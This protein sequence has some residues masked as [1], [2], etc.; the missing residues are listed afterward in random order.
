MIQT[1]R[2]SF[3]KGLISFAA[4]P[5]IVR[6]ES[7]MPVKVMR[8]IPCN[9]LDMGG[10]GAPQSTWLVQW[11]ETSIYRWFD[12]ATGWHTEYLSPEEVFL[13]A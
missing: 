9:V 13:P 5:A 7:L 10:L 4:A 1:S 2:R 8:P 3:I 12:E 6:V 11:G